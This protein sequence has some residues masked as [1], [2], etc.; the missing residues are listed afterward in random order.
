MVP[1]QNLLQLIAFIAGPLVGG[2]I[3]GKSGGGW[4]PVLIGAVVGLIIALTI[5]EAPYRLLGYL[6]RRRLQR[7]TTDGLYQ[8]LA[9]GHRHFGRLD[10]LRELRRRG[11]DI[12]SELPLLISF[13]SSNHAIERYVGFAAIR[14]FYP[15]IHHRLGD[16][17]P[18]SQAAPAHQSLPA[19]RGQQDP[20]P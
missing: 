8:A 3:A 13:L 17:E 10:I 4:L 2:M 12:D 5:V 15:H 16:Y 7:A 19:L 11:Q 1:L 18:Y 9:D 6:D 14:E 20:P